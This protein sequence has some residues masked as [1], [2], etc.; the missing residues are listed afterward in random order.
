MKRS[1]SIILVFFISNLFPQDFQ[2]INKVINITDSLTHA[3]ELRIYKHFS[4]SNDSEVLRMYHLKNNNWKIELYK[5]Y[6]AISPNEK[7]RF[8]LEYLYS[9]SNLY[10]L[11]TRILETHAE[12]LPDIKT[13]DY[14]LKGKTVFESDTDDY[15]STNKITFIYGIGY[16]AFI[17]N[18]NKVNQFNFTTSES[19]LK[20]FPEKLT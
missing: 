2:K 14:K 18:N 1:F 20:Y 4:T 13:I 17:R 19:Y 6:D 3:K 12:L 11:W 10:Q 5:F 9:D 7:P 15:G 16:I 8:T